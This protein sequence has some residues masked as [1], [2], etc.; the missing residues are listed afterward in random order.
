MQAQKDQEKRITTVNRNELL[1]KLCDN[2]KK[3]IKDYD[4]AMKGYK[5]VLLSKID[6]A[7]TKARKDLEAKNIAV[8]DKVRGL[9]DEDITKQSD[10]FIILDTIYV[11]MKVPRSYADEYRAAI[12]LFTWEVE[13]TVELSYAEFGCF[14]RDMWDWQLEFKAISAMYKV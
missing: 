3:H 11:D 7:F 10:R 8:V 1:N 12:D 4:E 5:S 9:T 6:L 13:E 14:V 2:L